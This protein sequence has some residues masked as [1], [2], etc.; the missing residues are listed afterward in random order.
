MQAEQ[1]E[2][3]DLKNKYSDFLER[4]VGTLSSPS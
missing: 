3:T 4:E 2:I 1:G